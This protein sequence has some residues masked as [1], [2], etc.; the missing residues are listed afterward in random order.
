MVELIFSIPDRVQRA[1]KAHVKSDSEELQ[2]LPP[3][4]LTSEVG[5]AQSANEPLPTRAESPANT[6]TP[7]TMSHKTSVQR[8]PSVLTG[9]CKHRPKPPPTQHFEDTS[10]DPG[11][12]SG[13]DGNGSSSG[14]SIDPD[15]QTPAKRLWISTIST[16]SSARATTPSAAEARIT[17]EHEGTPP[18]SIVVTTP[19]ESADLQPSGTPADLMG[20]DNAT[21][22]PPPID[23]HAGSIPSTRADSTRATTPP[24]TEFTNGGSEHD[25]NRSPI[26]DVY[27]IATVAVPPT[28]SSVTD[29]DKVPAFLCR[30]GTGSRHVDIFEYLNRVKDPHFQQ[31]LF[32]YINFEINDQSNSPGSLPTAKRPSEIAQWTAR[33]RPE[34]LPDYTKGKR[35][36]SVFVD[37]VL[38]WWSSLQ[39]LWRSFEWGVVSRQVGGSWGALYAPR[40]NGML[41]VVILAYWW[42]RVLEEQKPK[43]GNRTDYEFFADDIS[44]VLSQLTT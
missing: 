15:V 7:H 16:R 2:A 36:F 1:L 6:T 4:A 28:S 23:T 34:G 25:F 42:I 5:G 18:D 19:P 43:D 21:N 9:K 39:P 29:P 44:W 38:A 40:I 14:E 27:S 3:P 24:A 37:S 35:A 11:D 17:V 26:T 10:S 22:D 30:H 33:A 20:V 31:V 12:A 32:H 13:L 8:K 41:N